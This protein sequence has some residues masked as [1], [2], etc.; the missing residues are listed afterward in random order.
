MLHVREINSKNVIRTLYRD[1]FRDAALKKTFP[2]FTKHPDFSEAF[3]L[4]KLQYLTLSGLRILRPC[5]QLVSFVAD[6]PTL[7]NMAHI[8]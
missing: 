3:A 5:L 8:R 7:K 4:W 1:T 6:E 2:V